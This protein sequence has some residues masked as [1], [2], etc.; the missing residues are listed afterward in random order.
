MEQA[1]RALLTDSPPVTAPPPITIGVQ[2][3]DARSG[4]SETQRLRH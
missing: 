3:V 1:E 4:K 2:G